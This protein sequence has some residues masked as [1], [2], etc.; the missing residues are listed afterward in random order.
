MLKKEDF[1]WKVHHANN[2]PTN[3][4]DEYYCIIDVGAHA[5]KYSIEEQFPLR[6]NG[7]ICPDEDSPEYY[8]LFESTGA[9]ATDE[10]KKKMFYKESESECFT[11]TLFDGY[12]FSHNSFIRVFKTI[13][14][15][16]EAAY[17]QYKAIYGF[18]LAHIIDDVE[19]ATSKH[20]CAT[21]GEATVKTNN[22]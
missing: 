20:F 12:V 5:R 10:D 11:A 14:E 1:S 9:K 6:E 16:K 15:A 22:K 3:P 17:E 2:I 19:E 18:V 4:I 21:T 8:I 7:C 13:E